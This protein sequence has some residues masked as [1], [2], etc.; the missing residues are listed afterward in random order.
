MAVDGTRLD[1]GPKRPAEVDR[2]AT[3][4]SG[5]VRLY[6][7]SVENMT[8]QIGIIDDDRSFVAHLTTRLEEA[9]YEVVS[10]SS[11]QGALALVAVHRV[12]TLL[13]ELHLSGGGDGIELLRRL[14]AKSPDTRIIVMTANASADDYKR[15]LRM[16][17]MEVLSKPFP[18]DTLVA[19]LETAS[20][21]GFRGTLHGIGLV[22][23]LQLLHLGRRSV[24]LHFAQGSKVH[25][26]DGEVIHAEHGPHSGF[27]ALQILLSAN[28]GSVQTTELETNRQTIS[29][30]FS[31]LMLQ[32]MCA[33]DERRGVIDR[34]P[35][36]GRR[37][38]PALPESAFSDIPYDNP[39]PRSRRHEP[40]SRPASSP[41]NIPLI[42]HSVPLSGNTGHTGP[43]SEHTGLLTEH[44]GPH[45]YIS[46]SGL[47]PHNTM[48]SIPALP[49]A[50]LGSTTRTGIVA[51]RPTGGRPW[52]AIVL[53][54]ILIGVP[55]GYWFAESKARRDGGRPTVILPVPSGTAD[56]DFDAPAAET[57]RVVLL[58]EPDGLELR[59]AKTGDILG[60][61]P[62]EIELREV[63]LPLQ[64]Q[65]MTED[66]PSPILVAFDDLPSTAIDRRVLNFRRVL[67]RADIAVDDN[68]GDDIEA[69]PRAKKRARRSR[70]DRQ[71]TRSRRRSRRAEREEAE[72]FER[73]ESET[74]LDTSNTPNIRDVPPPSRDDDDRF[75]TAPSARGAAQGSAPQDAG[76]APPPK[77]KAP[78][79]ETIDEDQPT[80][81][82]VD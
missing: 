20:E 62:I 22:D 73:F 43:R 46:V 38:S 16:G 41:L 47:S 42:G 32:T 64:V 74:T 26:K 15:A 48:A 29:V 66:G 24:S 40:L 65:A 53:T 30:A 4:S 1:F 75:V 55:A 57:R 10:A 71:T 45:S 34:P 82:T 21:H 8:M 79:F 17:A 18:A 49:M 35:I 14:Q 61:S 5:Y 81:E 63:D 9:G 44:S 2:D 23:L 50:E 70:E 67:K 39:Q 33:I 31:G 19:A 69:R 28:S 51:E 54:M 58:T 3:F 25:M 68:D 77:K 37:A 11:V 72:P 56:D 78:V 60:R 6:A 12:H 80:F 59:N 27:R 13:M 52:I 76:L 7:A 36:S